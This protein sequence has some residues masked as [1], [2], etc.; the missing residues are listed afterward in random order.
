MKFLLIFCLFLTQNASAECWS[1]KRN[2]DYV[3]YLCH[4]DRGSVQSWIQICKHTGALTVQLSG[5]HQVEVS[6]LDD[7]SLYLEVLMEWVPGKVVDRIR[8]TAIDIRKRVLE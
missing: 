5:G 6:I 8:Q 2:D 4:D 1:E 3:L 7:L